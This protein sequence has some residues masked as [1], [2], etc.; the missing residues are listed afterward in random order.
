[1]LIAGVRLSHVWEHDRYGTEVSIVPVI[2]TNGSDT[3]PGVYA[4]V[5][6]AVPL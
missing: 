1:L 6:W 5:R 4:T 3:I 2:A